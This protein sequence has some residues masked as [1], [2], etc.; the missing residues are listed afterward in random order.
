MD[1]RRSEPVFVKGDK[2]SPKISQKSKEI[3]KQTAKKAT[4]TKKS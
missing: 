3:K 4:P 1:I 2:S